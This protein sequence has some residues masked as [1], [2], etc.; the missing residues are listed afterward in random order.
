MSEQGQQLSH[1]DALSELTRVWKMLHEERDRIKHLEVEN[2]DL[3]APVIDERGATEIIPKNRPEWANTALAEGTFFSVALS[4]VEQLETEID[5]LRAK[6]EMTAEEKLA[7]IQEQRR[8]AS[9]KYRE[10]HK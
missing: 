7:R 5:Q 3:S 4:K 1:E 6:Y 8:K 2:A 9:K 10:K